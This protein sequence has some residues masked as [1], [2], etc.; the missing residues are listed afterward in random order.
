MLFF[1]LQCFLYKTLALPMRQEGREGSRLRF[2]SGGQQLRVQLIP[3][4]GAPPA[5]GTS[6]IPG[7]PPGEG[8][9]C[10]AGTVF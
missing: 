7:R 3:A 10:G 5:A 8:S 2:G 1:L 9:V 4:P 6:L